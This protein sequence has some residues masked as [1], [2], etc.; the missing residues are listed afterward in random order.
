MAAKKNE[1]IGY[2]TDLHIR[3]K[4]DER[5]ILQKRADEMGTT[6]SQ[7][8]R[9]IIFKRIDSGQGGPADVSEKEIQFRTQQCIQ[10]V[11]NS[12]KKINTDIG[13]VVGGYE[14][15]LTLTNR[16]GDPAVSTEQTIRTVASLVANQ[17]KLQDGLNDIIRTF[18]GAEVHVAAK[19]PTGTAVGDYMAGK[20]HEP[21][22][23]EKG[24]APQKA[25]ALP[26]H[27]EKKGNNIEVIPPEFRTMVNITFN[28]T[29][30]A[31]VETYKDGQYEKIRLQVKVENY[32]NRKTYVRLFDATDFINRYRNVM[33]HLKEGKQVLIN[34]DF[35][36]SADEYNGVESKA[37]GTVVISTLTLL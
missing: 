1:D 6:L 27:V 33:P 22:K 25:I 20:S 11:K 7:A 18:G 34:G 21:Q 15:S 19:P 8:A 16:S 9:R 37:E 26:E 24:G 13:K 4:V 23:S 3:L 29:L 30:V 32:F 17:I 12:F 31:D 5:D 14:R 36:M 2:T 35:D 28:G 10:A